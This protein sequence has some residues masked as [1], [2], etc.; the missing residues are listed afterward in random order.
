MTFTL[1]I[2][3]GEIVFSTIYLRPLF[4]VAFLL[5][6]SVKPVLRR[7]GST[8]RHGSTDRVNL[9]FLISDVFVMFVIDSSEKFR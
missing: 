3:T 9:I 8:D 1:H 4:I 6:N 7:Y 5:K 2:L